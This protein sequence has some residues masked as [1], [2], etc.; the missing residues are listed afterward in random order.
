MWCSTVHIQTVGPLQC[1]LDMRCGLDVA[2]TC[3]AGCI[4]GVLHR[5][6]VAGQWVSPR[7]L[8][9]PVCRGEDLMYVVMV[10]LLR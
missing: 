9:M 3:K 1:G 2:W 7:I 8:A 5:E 6:A 10:M 4:L